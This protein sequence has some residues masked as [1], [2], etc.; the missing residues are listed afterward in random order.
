MRGLESTTWKDGFFVELLGKIS[1]ELGTPSIGSNQWGIHSQVMPGDSIRALFFPDRWRSRTTPWK[2]HMNSPSQK[3][4]FES[5]GG[6]A[7]QNTCQQKHMC[8]NKISYTKMRWY[9]PIASCLRY[10]NQ[11]FL[12]CFEKQSWSNQVHG[13]HG[14]SEQTPGGSMDGLTNQIKGNYMDVSKNSGTPKSSIL[15]GFSIINHPFWGSPIFGNTHMH[16]LQFV[17]CFFGRIV[18]IDGKKPCQTEKE[19]NKGPRGQLESY[20]FRFLKK[21]LHSIHVWLE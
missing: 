6:V 8:K 13:I 17:W 3:G 5:P 16:A 21:M 9:V 1:G 10:K 12:T 4:H 20:S 7:F 15:I 14:A 19:H 18:K 2:G 11:D